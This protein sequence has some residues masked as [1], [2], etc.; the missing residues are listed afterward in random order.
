MPTLQ[1]GGALYAM[2]GFSPDEFFG[3]VERHRITCTFVVPVMIY[4]LLDSPLA[5]TAD[6]SSLETIFYGASAIS[7]TRLAEGVEKWGQIFFQCYGQSEAPMVLSHLKKAD[8]DPSRPHRLASC[9]RPTPWV[10]AG[11]AR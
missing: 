5:D 10:R 3:M 2:A 8:H 6:L 9:G 7:P 4:V 11:T 1:K